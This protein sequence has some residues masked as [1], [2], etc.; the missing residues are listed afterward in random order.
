MSF[1]FFI[2]VQIEAAQINTDDNQE[3][4]LLSLC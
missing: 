4:K 2:V 1:I 3:T